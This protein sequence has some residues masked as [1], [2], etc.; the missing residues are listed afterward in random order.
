MENRYIANLVLWRHV[1]LGNKKP[2]CAHF[3]MLRKGDPNGFT[4]TVRCFYYMRA[5]QY[6][7]VVN[8]ET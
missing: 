3:F 1:N 4:F 8:Y 7:M 2:Y 5:C 6:P